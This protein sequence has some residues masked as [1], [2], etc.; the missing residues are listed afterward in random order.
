MNILKEMED[1]DIDLKSIIF[2]KF[3]FGTANDL[4]RTFKWGPKPS[5]K[6]KNDLLYLCNELHSAKETGFD[7]W[8]INILTDSEKGDVE[9]VDGKDLISF[10]QTKFK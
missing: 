7:I 8:E 5:R 10:E 4:S 2:T 1:F 3:P 6:M 9:Y